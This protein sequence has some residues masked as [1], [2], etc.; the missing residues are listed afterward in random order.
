MCWSNRE[1]SKQQLALT[2]ARNPLGLGNPA[3]KELNL[4]FSVNLVYFLSV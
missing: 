2:R 4:K 3:D 1:G